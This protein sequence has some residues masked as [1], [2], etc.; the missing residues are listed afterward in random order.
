VLYLEVIE[1]VAF[2]EAIAKKVV[3]G[4]LG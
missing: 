2:A 1:A 3:L 4:F